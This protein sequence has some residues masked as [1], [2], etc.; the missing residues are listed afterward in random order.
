V[1]HLAL[2]HKASFVEFVIRGYLTGT[3]ELAH[4]WKALIGPEVGQYG[5][6]SNARSTVAYVGLGANRVQDAIYPTAEYDANGDRLVSGK[7]YVLVFPEAISPHGFLS[8]TAYDSAGNI[9][10]SRG[11]SG[12]HLMLSGVEVG[13]TVAINPYPYNPNTQSTEES[14]AE[15][16]AEATMNVCR[17]GSGSGNNTEVDNA[18]DAVDADTDAC[19]SK[20]K[21]YDHS[22]TVVRGDPSDDQTRHFEITLR[23]Y[24]PEM[25]T[26]TDTD[27]D[28]T[29]RTENLKFSKSSLPR[30]MPVVQDRQN[31]D[32]RMWLQ[33]RVSAATAV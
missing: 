13:T 1:R 29:A 17:S 10:P 24:S 8:L 33:T 21:K 22:F 2:L 9:S 18:G 12:A 31:A 11:S 32:S 25:N 14:E 30:I 20:K 5:G 16:E 7:S 6:D 15:A 26:D 3:V 4:G 27:I 19:R 28:N 23:I